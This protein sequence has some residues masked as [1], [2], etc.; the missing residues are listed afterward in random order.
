MQNFVLIFS[1]HIWTLE[2]H[3]IHPTLQGSETMLN[4]ILRILSGVPVF[5]MRHQSPHG[6]RRGFQFTRKGSVVS[7]GFELDVRSTDSDIQVHALEHFEEIEP[8]GQ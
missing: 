1:H 2:V 5:N 4:D 6:R 3:N 8:H 7:V